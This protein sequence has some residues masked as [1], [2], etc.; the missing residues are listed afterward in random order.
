MDGSSSWAELGP[1]GNQCW[2]APAT[3]P[4]EA[5]TLSFWLKLYSL[6]AF[7]GVV[8]TLNKIFATFTA[9]FDVYTSSG[10]I[11]MK[12]RVMP[13]TVYLIKHDALILSTWAYCTLVWRLD[14]NPHHFIYY[15]NG[16]EMTASDI[17]NTETLSSTGPDKLVMGR[18]LTG[19]HINN[20]YGNVE[21]DNLIIITA[22]IS[23]ADVID[24]HTSQM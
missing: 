1:G 24:L 5:L 11:K 6:E 16:E 19:S 20:Y 8:S 3:C 18:V 2:Y 21:I 14:G 12:M 4:R 23:E 9:G 15:N 10:K 17:T 7:G 13:N 22:R